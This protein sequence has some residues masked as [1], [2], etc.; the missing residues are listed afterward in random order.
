MQN[1]PDQVK[2]AADA[3]AVAGVI[4]F[5]VGFFTGVFGLVASAATAVWAV[6]RMWESIERR[7]KKAGQKD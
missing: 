6:M 3:A 5:W 1:L 7:R 2:Y 4:S